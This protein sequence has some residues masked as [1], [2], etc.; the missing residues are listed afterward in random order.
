M[1]K[2]LLGVLIA[3][4]VLVTACGGDSDT[5]SAD[6]APAEQ[7]T[8]APAAPEPADEDEPA[9]EP[10]PADENEPAAEPEP[11]DEDEPAAEPEPADEDEPAAEPEATPVPLTASF[12]GVTETEIRIGMTSL[13]AEMFGF[14]QGDLASKWQVAVDAVN[15][16]G[17]INGRMLVPFIEVIDVIGSVGADAA[18]VK[19]VE[20]EMVFAFVGWLREDNEL[21]Y[22]ELNNTIAVNGND[23]TPDAI[24]R[25]NGMLFATEATTLG[26]QRNMIAAAAADGLI[27]GKRVHFSLLATEEALVEPLVASLEAAGATISSVSRVT[28]VD[29]VQAAEANHDVIVQ[30][31]ADENPD[32]V[33]SLE[34]ELMAA[35]LIRAGLDIPMITSES[36]EDEYQ[37][38][39]VDPNAVRLH[40][41]APE[42]NKTIWDRGNDPLLI[43]CVE[44]YNNAQITDE[45]GN[46]ETVNVTEDPNQPINLDLVVKACQTVWLFAAIA[47]AA[48]PNLTNDSFLE[49]A[50]N[51][52]VINLPGMSSASLGEGKIGADDSPMVKVIWD[53]EEEEFV[54]AG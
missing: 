48:G 13:D 34:P 11:A 24:N 35:A 18:C 22:T 49:A 44:N 19:F 5:G 39:G 30:R 26:I 31:I 53:A 33:Y 15:A 52:G 14:D 12:R 3:L 2:R 21:C 37:N 17:G 10:E 29:D 47:T 8:D 50:A 45:D 7:P 28:A 25:S 9:E 38:L 42:Q 27:D 16:A 43:E 51:L 20:D 41:F 23:V 4:S 6:D 32:L 40:V 1:Y 46:V 36:D 54:P